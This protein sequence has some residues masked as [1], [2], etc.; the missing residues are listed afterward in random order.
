MKF[1][2]TSRMTGTLLLLAALASAVVSCGDAGTAE[3][4]TQATDPTGTDA[5][6]EAVTE[7]PALMDN[8]PETD[9][10]GDAFRMMIFGT[11]ERRAQTYYDTEDGNIVNDAV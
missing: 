1:N 6:T 7:D 4:V 10:G 5:V 11:D 9:M 3:S 8:L 2:H